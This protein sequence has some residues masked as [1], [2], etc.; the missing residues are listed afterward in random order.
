MEHGVHHSGRQTVIFFTE[1]TPAKTAV[2]AQSVRVGAGRPRPV[3]RFKLPEGGQAAVPL[4]EVT[5]GD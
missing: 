3:L 5:S 2:L 1:V 4:L